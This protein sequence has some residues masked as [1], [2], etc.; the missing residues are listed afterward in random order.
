M[1]LKSSAGFLAPAGCFAGAPESCPGT[2]VREA[3]GELVL[4]WYR[5]RNP[6][7]LAATH[8]NMGILR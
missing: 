8:R 7:P 1:F 5:L 4:I 2:S 6:L 3:C